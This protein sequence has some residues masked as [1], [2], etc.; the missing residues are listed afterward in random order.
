MTRAYG[1]LGL[2]LA[3]VRELVELHHGQVSAESPGDG[4]GAT[5]TVLVPLQAARAPRS[6]FNSE[7]V[8]LRHSV[9]EQPRSLERPTG[10]GDP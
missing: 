8:A 5:F 7:P 4:A 9:D 3:I 10:G 6:V 1:G 2:G